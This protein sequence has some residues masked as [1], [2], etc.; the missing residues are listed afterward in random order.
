MASPICVIGTAAFYRAMSLYR[1]GQSEEA[2]K[3]AIEAVAKMK[4]LPNPPLDQHDDMILWM[5]YKEAKTMI[6]FEGTPLPAAN[7]NQK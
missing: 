1:L 6:K 5:A 7:G 3:V 2:S 4:P